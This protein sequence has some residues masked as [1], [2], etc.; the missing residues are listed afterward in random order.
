MR[1]R[2]AVPPAAVCLASLIIISPQARSQEQPQNAAPVP[3][4][5]LTVEASKAPAK[6]K[7]KKAGATKAAAPAQASSASTP[8]QAPPIKPTNP[9]ANIGNLPATYAGGQ[10]ATGGQ[11]GIL[12]N[13]GVMDTPFNQTSY[14]SQLMQDQQSHFI[15]DALKNNPSVV[16]SYPPS[17]GFDYFT[18]RGL[19]VNNTDILFNGMAGVG[20]TF[21]NSMMSESIERVEL[22]N[23]P[24][25]LLN[26][27]APNGSVGGTINL[28]PKRAGDK[29]LTQVTTSYEMNSN[30][31]EHL[32]IGR[33]YGVD[34]EWGVRFNGS[35][36][37]G[38]MAI[39]NLSRESRMAALG[40]D[41]RGDRL[42]VSSDLGY[43]YQD[44]QGSRGSVG[45]ISVLPKAPDSRKNFSQPWEF[46]TPEV[47]YGT[48]SG[49]LDIT[50]NITVFAAIG[51]S[52][53]EWQTSSFYTTIVNADGDLAAG[54]AWAV[55][56]AD[57]MISQTSQVGVRST[58]DTGPISH[59]AVIGYSWFD[60]EW[61]SG[62]GPG[63]DIPASNIYNPTYFYGIPD[64]AFHSDP[65]DA[66]K[67][68][69]LVLTSGIIGDTMSI[70]DKRV[71]L[72]VGAR[73]QRIQQD[74]F[75]MGN[76]TGS[77]DE[78]AVTPMVGLVVKPLHNVSLYGNYIQGLQQG[79]TAP[80]EAVNRGEIFPPFVT[81]QYEA[82]IKVDFG[83]IT[84]TLAAYQISVPSAYLDPVSHVFSVSGEQRNRGLEFNV[85]GELTETIRL[86]GGVSLINAEL[87]STVGG[88]NDGN[89]G[90]GVPDYSVVAGAEWDTP[91]LKGLTLT[92]RATYTSA[93]Y[94]NA[95]NSLRAPGWAR[96][97]VG[98]RYRFERADGKPIIIRA[99]IENVLDSNYWVTDTYG[100]L[101]LS[102]PLTFKMSATLDF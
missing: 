87:T 70:L 35:Y 19:N 65:D 14:T 55:G 84:T 17:S 101:L 15:S 13:R 67:I 90:I 2:S 92:G 56:R 71:Q 31:G 83:A 37:D 36:R 100:A 42:R 91:F 34:K 16:V 1:F 8:P 20:P 32:D 59:Q 39:E 12:G 7:K 10:V 86:L 24:S 30:F 49:E 4:P 89:T 77:Y 99:N 68:Q 95:E 72:T 75:W 76:V 11:V 27:M 51:G 48:L 47:Y 60:R 102:D 44:L 18:I 85:F 53:R 63:F 94:I 58:F 5:P 38:D 46:S 25:A 23:G 78:N 50:D 73:L 22:L 29:P 54:N 45:A 41:Y 57:K 61:R 9:N 26:G 66:P 33:R 52:Q 6:K 3:L 40:L 28:V 80:N 43:Q 82:G 81:E 21:A 62:S 79:Q 98:A 93:M 64:S 69:Q 88:K 96:F 74:N 97:D